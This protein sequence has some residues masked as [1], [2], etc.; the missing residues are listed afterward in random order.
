MEV[1]MP[2]ING[3]KETCLHVDNMAR[4]R[5]FYEGVMGFEVMAADARF[6]AYDAGGQ[7]V[8]LLFLRGGSVD[9]VI[10]PGGVIPPH[11]GSGRLHV[12][13]AIGRG[14]LPE[15]EAHLTANGVTI[16]ST[17]DWPRG[18]RS[19]YFRDPDGHLLE[20]LTPGVWAIY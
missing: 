4:A 15:W 1:D 6:C 5:E 13:F 14:E 12:G 19:L 3:V 8:L 16:E 18:G 7:S 17:V 9:G 11:D 20:V 2:A 10:L